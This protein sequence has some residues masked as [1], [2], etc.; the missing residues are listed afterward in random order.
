MH[1]NIRGGAV[2]VSNPTLCAVTEHL[3]L[4]F[5]LDEWVTKI[6]TSHLAAR[7]AGTNDELFEDCDKLT[8]YSVLH[9]TS[10]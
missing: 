5:S 7:F 9:R 3:S 2:I 1:E 10:G 4:P 6:D 8:L